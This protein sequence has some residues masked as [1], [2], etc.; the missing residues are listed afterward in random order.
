MNTGIYWNKLKQN[1]SRFEINVNN[2]TLKE[3]IP[4]CFHGYDI[5]SGAIWNVEAIKNI[6]PI[7]FHQEN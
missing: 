1:F 6:I 3:L 2:G 4:D 7:S 5:N